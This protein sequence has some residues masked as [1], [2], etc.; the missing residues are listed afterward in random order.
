MKIIKMNK[1]LIALD[2]NPTAQKVADVGYSIASA[3]GAECVLIHILATPILYTSM[4]YDPIMGFSG[5]GSFDNYQL[6]TELLSKTAMNY[7][8]EVKNHLGDSTIKTIV[9]EGQFAQQI[10][11]AATINHADLIVMGTHSHQWLEK[12]LLGSTAE[13]IIEISKIP[14][15]IVPTK[16]E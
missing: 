12:I 16:K 8:D 14:I 13:S 7:L 4:N 15:V 9:K 1:V 5:F 11:E 3:L 10:I 2:Y 6:D